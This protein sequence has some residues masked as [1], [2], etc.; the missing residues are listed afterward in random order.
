MKAPEMRLLVPEVCKKPF[1]QIKFDLLFQ[2]HFVKIGY[3]VHSNTLLIKNFDYCSERSEITLYHNR[4][5]TGKTRFENNHEE[6]FF[7]RCPIVSKVYKFCRHLFKR[8]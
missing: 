2:A 6:L 4:S 7:L 1:A 5:K 8:Q 3:L